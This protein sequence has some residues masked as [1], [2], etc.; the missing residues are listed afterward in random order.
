MSNEEQT[1]ALGRA[2]E[3][4]GEVKR[5]LAALKNESERLS[6]WLFAW[7]KFLSPSAK[8]PGVFRGDP[9]PGSEIRH[10]PTQEKIDALVADIKSALER[11][12]QLV[13]QLR[14]AGYEPKDDRPTMPFA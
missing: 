2:L 5:R 10:V 13:D 11:K 1:M 9:D 14:E 6:G 3:E 12:Q 4:H 8:G 7:G